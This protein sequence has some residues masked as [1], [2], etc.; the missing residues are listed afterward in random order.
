MVKCNCLIF[1]PSALQTGVCLF[2]VGIC[3]IPTDAQDLC[4]VSK[5]NLQVMEQ[6]QVALNNIF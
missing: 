6:M 4:P 2:P 3:S 1:Q 5:F